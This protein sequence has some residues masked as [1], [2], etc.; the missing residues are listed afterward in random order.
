MTRDPPIALW[1]TMFAMAVQHV[2]AHLKPPFRRWQIPTYQQIN[3][4]LERDSR[5]FS[6]LILCELCEG[7]RHVVKHPNFPVYFARN[8]PDPGDELQDVYRNERYLIEIFATHDP[9]TI[10]AWINDAH[11]D[12][13]CPV[14]RLAPDDN[15]RTSLF[16]TYFEETLQ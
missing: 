3:E 6:D 14:E 4:L 1:S 5:L 8:I 9:K 7:A 13:P 11:P 2:V 15:A 10:M 16:P 12:D